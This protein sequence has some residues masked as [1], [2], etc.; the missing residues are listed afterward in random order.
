MREEKSKTI[1]IYIGSLALLL[2]CLFP[3][4]WML[5]VSI[6]KSPAFLATN[7]SFQFTL[8]NYKEILFNESLHFVDYL[9]N[10]LIISLVAAVCTTFFTSISAYAITRLKFPGRGLLPLIL[11]AF[12]MFPQISIV[13]YLFRLIT[14]LG[15]INTYAA[16]IFP[17]ITIAIPLALWIMIS[18]LRQIPIELDNAA[19]VDGATR[20]QILRK[21]IFPLAAPGA[22][23][24]FLLIFIFCF[25]EFLFALMLTVDHTARTIP[26][27]IALFQGLHGE[28]PW[29]EI[30]AAST[31]A[32]IPLIILAAISQRYIIQGLTRG[33][34]KG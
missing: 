29:G 4:I 21:V 32:S 20:V 11:L 31:I 13:G 10:S 30:M 15:W 8:Q 17:Y 34:L 6:S 14:N 23:A 9:K 12:S 33:A 1:F 24:T 3:F 5:I 22:F 28:I 7:T 16:L 2:F 25:N 19:L 26:V 18:Y 27:G